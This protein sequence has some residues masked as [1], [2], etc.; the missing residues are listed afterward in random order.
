MTSGIA[1][2][3]GPNDR[4]W[5]LILSFHFLFYFSLGCFNYWIESLHLIAKM[6]VGLSMLIVALQLVISE[7]LSQSFIP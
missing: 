2:S 4:T 1:E 5:I 6:V 3:R 7:K